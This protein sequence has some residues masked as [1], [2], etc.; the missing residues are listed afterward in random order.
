MSFVIRMFKDSDG[1]QIVNLFYETIHAVNIRDYTQEQ[2]DAWA[3]KLSGSELEER[4]KRFVK[5]LGESITYV[6]D[7]EGVVIGFANIT[8]D[9]YLDFMFVHKD[10]QGQGVASNLLQILQE[11]A[12][13][14]GVKRVWANVSITA[15]PFFERHGFVTVQPQTVKRRGVSINNFR[16]EKALLR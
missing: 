6:A 16:M 15:K 4:V 7:N 13:R 1:R 9:G 14:L 5:S 2:V 10:Y 3:P 8:E 11:E 12:I